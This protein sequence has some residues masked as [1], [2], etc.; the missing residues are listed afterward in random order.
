MTRRRV[1]SV[2]VFV[3]ASALAADLPAATTEFRV[4]MDVDNDAATGCT[5]AGMAGVDQTLTTSVE[6]DAVAASV[7]RTYREV[8]SG[9]VTGD[10]I[11]VSGGGWGVGFQPSSGSVLVETRIPF[12]AFSAD[13]MPADIRIGIQARQGVAGHTVLRRPDGSSVLFPTAPRGKRRSAASPGGARLMSLDG[14][15][16][17]WQFVNALFDGIAAGGDSS[18]RIIRFFGYA[19]G[20][21]EHLYFRFDAHISMDAPFAEDDTFT[22]PEGEGLNV[23]AP[24]VLAND[25]EPTG[26]PLT[27]L[28]AADPSRGNLTLNPDGSF[29]YTPAD[30]SSTKADM[31]EY[32]ASNGTRSSN[33]ARVV[34]RVRSVRNHEPA[35][36][37]DAYHASE[38]V[39][40]D[41]ASPGVLLNDSDPDDDTLTALLLAAP[42]HG[43]VV[44]SASGGFTYS[45]DA[46][47]S[48]GDSFTYSV[49]DGT[50]SDTATVTIAVDAMNDAPVAVADVY[51]TTLNTA[52]DATA[53]GVL[54]NDSDREGDA[55]TAVL[56]TDVAHGTLTLNA[57]GSFHYAPAPGFSGTDSFSYRAHDGAAESAP[58]TVTITVRATNTAPVANAQ[59]VE[60]DEDGAQSIT[61]TAT[62]ADGDALTYA[63]TDAPDHGTLLR[64]GDAVW[65]YSPESNYAGTD[66]FSFSASDG[67]ATDT[68]TVTIEVRSVNDAP[69][70]NDDLYGTVRDTP[71]TV[72]APG[73]ITND[74]DP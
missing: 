5:V 44:L 57:N 7:S 22:R 67:F 13:A 34:I 15:D 59:A 54:G 2:F 3:L 40:L 60:V 56:V 30:P 11:E 19:D 73:V 47:F 38:D 37:D 21:G 55:L 20:A 32:R 61:L 12:S 23:D 68:A 35:G 49:S 36:V 10:A 41:V 29:T 42:S 27:A 18:L 66:S 6:S 16:S 64:T 53:P 65:T 4:L 63:I 14:L 33:T 8:C 31:F 58:V 72:A 1:L 46:D 39:V 51:A 70:A 45:P 50:L 9:G 28:P 52:L 17:D 25:D 48:G 24:G 43:T 69:F 26:A 62:D 74:H 71:L